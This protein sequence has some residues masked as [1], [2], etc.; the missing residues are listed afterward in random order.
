[1]LV[2]ASVAVLSH[3]KGSTRKSSKIRIKRVVLDFQAFEHFL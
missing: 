2:D 3:H 1:V